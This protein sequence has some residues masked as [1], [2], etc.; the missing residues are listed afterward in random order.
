MSANIS[1]L[2]HILRYKLLIYLFITY[3]SP[4]RCCASHELSLALSISLPILLSCCSLSWKFRGSQGRQQSPR[5]LLVLLSPLAGKLREGQQFPRILLILLSRLAGKSRADNNFL[6]SCLFCC[7]H[8]PANPG[9]TT[10]SPDLA[11]FVVPTA[12]RTTGG[13]QFPRIL[14]ILLSPRA[15]NAATD[16]RWTTISPDLAYFVVPA[17]QKRRDRPTVDNNFLESCLFC[18]PQWQ[19][20]TH[21]RQK[22]RDRP[23]VDNNFLGSCLFCCPQWQKSHPRGTEKPRP[24]RKKAHTPRKSPHAPEKPTRTCR[25]S[26]GT[27]VAATISP[28]PAS[29]LYALGYCAIILVALYVFLLN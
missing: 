10:I 26:R 22:R 24:P 1:Q 14:L 8:W 7:P 18:C 5:I 13:Q 19:K 3:Q 16:Q 12:R 27:S 17:S 11:Y 2:I 4:N 9:Q 28:I 15:R 29:N 21:A 6:G 20:A 23:T 25:E